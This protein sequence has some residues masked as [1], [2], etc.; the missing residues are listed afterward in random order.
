ML[1]QPQQAVDDQSI[2]NFVVEGIRQLLFGIV[3]LVLIVNVVMAH[4]EIEH[5]VVLV[6][7]DHWIIAAAPDLVLLWPGA[8]WKAG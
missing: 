1:A 4:V 7:P 8:E 3:I 6:R 2:L 5:L